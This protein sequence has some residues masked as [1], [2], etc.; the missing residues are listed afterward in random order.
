MWMNLKLHFKIIHGKKLIKQ[1]KYR[2]VPVLVSN[3]TSDDWTKTMFTNKIWIKP[4]IHEML[5][6]DFFIS[7]F[8]S[9]CVTYS[10]KLI[11]FFFELLFQ[12]NWKINS[13]WLLRSKR[14]CWSYSQFLRLSNN[15]FRAATTFVSR[16][17]TTINFNYS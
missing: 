12:F 6:R 9:I 15:E 1:I 7:V 11:F 5:A 16:T 13:N 14:H 8:Y 3:N 17:S 2:I 4:T 10:L